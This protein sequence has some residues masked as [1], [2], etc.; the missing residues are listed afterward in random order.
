M[1]KIFLVLFLSVMTMFWMGTMAVA[2]WIP[3]DGH[4]MH[5]PQLPNEQGWDVNATNPV[6][7]ADDWMCSETGWVKDIH[8]WGSWMHGI[9]GQIISFN[10]SIHSD[11]PANPPLIPY[12]RPGATLWEREIPIDSVMV[13]TYTSPDWE[14]WYDPE[15]GLWIPDDHNIYY[16]YNVFLSEPDWFWQEDGT[17]YWLNISATIDDPAATHWGWKSTLD[18]W[19]DDAVW[20][21][22]GA[23]NWIDMWEPPSFD[24]SL[25]LAFVITGGEEEPIGACCYPGP[26]TYLTQCVETTED[27]CINFYGGVYEGD[28][29]NCFGMQACCFFDGS[30]IDA[31]ALCCVVEL[32]GTPQGSGT[33]CGAVV[34]CCLPGG[35]CVMTDEICCDDV[36][37][38]PQGP[39]TM[40][41]QAEACCLPDGSCIM[42]D[43]LCCD[44]EGGTPQGP[45]TSC[46]P[47]EACCLGDG[48]CI[49]AD[50]ICCDDL[51]GTAQGPGTICSGT[52]VACCLPDGLCLDVDSLCCDDLGGWV[53]PF[54]PICLGDGDGNGIDDACEPEEIDTCEY[55]KPGY[56]DYSP[57]GMPDFDQKQNMWYI[58]I[59]PAQQWTHCGPVALG[60]CFWWFDSKFELSPVD[61]RPFWPGPGNPPLNDNYGL[62]SSY[63][64]SGVWDDHD[65]NNVI[66]H[67]DSMALYCQTN[68]NGPG[69]NVFDL[70][71][72]AR[73][74]L[75]N[76]GL[77]SDYTV[78]VFAVGLD[79]LPP[80][81][82]EFIR[83]QVLISQDIILL[84]GFWQSTGGDFCERV[85]GHYMTI[86]G[87]CTDPVDSAIC[88]SDPFLDKNE[89]IG[90]GASVH[91]DASLISGP[92]GTMHH[93]RY[94]VIPTTCMF[95]AP[96]V[97]QLEL[98]NY[99]VNPGNIGNFFGQNQ[100]DTSMAPIPPQPFPIHTVLEYIVVI[101]PVPQPTGACCWDTTGGSLYTEC[102]ITTEDSCTFIYNG[103][104]EGDGTICA[105]IQACC[106]E[107]YTCVNADALCCV[108]ELNGTPLGPGTLCTAPEACCFTDGT[109]I[110]MD[111]LCCLEEG[112]IPQNPGTTCTQLQ[113]C[114]LDNGDCVMVDP[115]CCDEQGGIPQGPGTT[116]TQLQAC[117]LDN[118]DCIMVDPLCCDEQGGVPQG[119]GTTCTQPEGCCLDDGTCLDLDPLCCD[120]LGGTPQGAGTACV[121]MTVACCLTDG[122]CLDVDP[123][124]CD[125]IGGFISPYSG[126]CLGDADS[127]GVDDACEEPTGACCHE[128][129][130]CTIETQADCEN[131]NGDYKGDNTICLGD[132]EGNGIDDLCEDWPFS[133]MHYPQLPDG[134]GWDVSA[135]EPMMLADDW[136]CIETGW[137]KDIHFWGSWLDGEIGY[138]VT[139]KLA[140]YT[141]IPA[142]PPQ[143]PYS[144]PGDMIWYLEVP[145]DDMEI[146]TISP[147]AEEGWYDPESGLILP[148]NH[149]Q[150][151]RYDVYLDSLDWFWQEEE[152]IYWL[153]ISVNVADPDQQQWG[154]KSSIDHWNDDAVWTYGELPPVW[155]ELYEPPQFMQSLDFAFVI[156]NG[157]PCF[158]MCGDANNDTKVNVADAVWIINYV[159]AG[160]MPPLPVLACG[161]ANNDCG[162][163]V[164]DAVW[165]INYVFAGGFPP[166]DCCPGSVSWW[167][168]D[169]CPFVGP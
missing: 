87:V 160:G 22:W 101:C 128:D 149:T 152:T 131:I 110:D 70:A 99:G 62:V 27:S 60:N 15:T 102:L 81:D 145:A 106:L 8:F 24:T 54:S 6:I 28:Y 39:G 91:N 85:G 92:H 165:V 138:Q 14:G 153:A 26:G 40:C 124:C 139:F 134:I 31:D 154:W 148:Q 166:G 143:V 53:S 16:L 9:E 151:Y 37:G 118:G 117:C 21:L 46:G 12:S 88:V 76:Q 33:A 36:G 167:D 58:G 155:V 1:K 68:V 116:C 121:D 126:F 66:P 130:S 7:L 89:P 164:A 135:M 133:K 140:I 168:G 13:I 34:A 122:S 29:S 129:G 20:A 35:T 56:E 2:D 5:Y 69:T 49:M 127:N 115:L 17:I 80:A 30:C 108:N 120:E 156:T 96:P 38:V 71:R 84:V 72:G 44:E 137:V 73:N 146:H 142:N 55:Y 47:H 18:R 98:A 109:C 67:I 103:V 112:G 65:T 158:G 10:L 77:G 48:S 11:I 119:P 4:K 105:G 114:C 147:S 64:P 74:W 123:L 3:E 132:I 42:V 136:M 57:N 125:D 83:E 50:P 94:D 43:P 169:C 163:N 141:D 113:A 107:D 75:N 100:Y 45:G 61:P 79:T 111:P 23:L 104:Y 19:N 32:G 162:V 51:G 97:F 52:T 59:P 25:N 144:R 41:T 161:D 157:R 78:Q 63:D 159:F 90:H 82:F 150:F 93:D 95:I 86:A